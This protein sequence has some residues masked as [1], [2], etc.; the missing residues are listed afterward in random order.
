M[1]HSLFGESWLSWKVIALLKGHGSPGRLWL[2]WKAMA[3]KGK[4][5][6]LLKGHGTLRKPWHFIHILLSSLFSKCST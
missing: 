5:M 4:G 1:C 3:L 2:F 6:T